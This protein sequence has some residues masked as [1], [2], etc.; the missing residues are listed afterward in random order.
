MKIE[1]FYLEEKKAPGKK[2]MM[3]PHRMLSTISAISLET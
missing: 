3:K 1:G 2:R